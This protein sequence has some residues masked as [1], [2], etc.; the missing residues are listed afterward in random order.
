[1]FNRGE[2]IFSAAENLSKIVLAR[3][4]LSIHLVRIK[5][6]SFIFKRN[7]VLTWDHVFI[8]TGLLN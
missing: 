1:M 8:R 6:A 4:E 7:P 5:N 3:I 2:R